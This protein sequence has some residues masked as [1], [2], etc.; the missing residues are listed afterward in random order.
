[1]T[2]SMP[3]SLSIQHNRALFDKIIKFIRNSELKKYEF[4]K[5]GYFNVLF[6]PAK[7]MFDLKTHNRSL[8]L[9]KLFLFNSILAEDSKTCMGVETA[10]SIEMLTKVFEGDKPENS[11]GILMYIFSI[12][13]PSYVVA[14]LL[15]PILSFLQLWNGDIFFPCVV[16]FLIA[17]LIFNYL[18]YTR[19]RADL[20]DTY[21]SLR[22][23]I[24]ELL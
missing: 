1:M 8:D 24:Q 6:I 19:I 5:K 18:E 13:S 15:S 21:I 3:Q 17:T 12:I 14:I 9:L 2:D 16:G 4:Q 7:F 23:E 22:K 11:L 20:K 10:Y